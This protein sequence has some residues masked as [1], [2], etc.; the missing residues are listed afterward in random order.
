[1]IYN[2]NIL[3]RK[4]IHLDEPLPLPYKKFLL[5]FP[6]LSNKHPTF[7]QGEVSTKNV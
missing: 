3:H 2:Y 6:A 7:L 5:Q 4:K 1:M